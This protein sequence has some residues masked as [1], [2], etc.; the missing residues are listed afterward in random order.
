MKRKASNALRIILLLALFIGTTAAAMHIIDLH[1]ADCP[2]L[3]TPE[4]DP[5]Y[6]PLIL[7]AVLYLLMPLVQAGLLHASGC[8]VMAVYVLFLHVRFDDGI[9][10]G[11]GRPGM[12]T[13]Y[14][15]PRLD[16]TS[17][18]VLP[19][20]SAPLCFLTYSAMCT[21]LL[22]PT[23]GSYA[24][25][26]LML[27][28]YLG[29]VITLTLLLPRKNGADVLSRVLIL[30]K[31]KDYVR[32]LECSMHVSFALSQGKKLLDMPE[33]WFQTYPTETAEDLYVS[34]CI[35]NG[36]S[37]LIRQC[38]FQ[39]AY[40]MLRPLFDLNPTP[41]NHQVISCSI[42]NGAICEALTGL[43]PMCLSQLEH[44]SVKYMTPPTWQPRLLTAKYARALLLNHDEA[45]AAV[46][47]EE[48]TKHIEQNDID[49]RLVL[50]LQ[51]KAGAK[52]ERA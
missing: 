43:P 16:G 51:E 19:L 31:G 36:S 34:N 4:A 30:R 18:Y 52:E 46:L 26:I 15:L 25:R 7:G 3:Y 21:L 6:R 48:M 28:A 14:L 29:L 50:L 9:Q 45:E 22:I 27:P 40:A 47:L 12:G 20:L 5:G 38:R 8:Q 41:E 39:E 37:R 17:P 2:W 11:L 42:L 10:V 1:A 44:T 13:W 32:A 24:A 49:R 35:I 33:E 23:W